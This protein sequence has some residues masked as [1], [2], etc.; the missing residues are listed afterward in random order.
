MEIEAL[1]NEMKAVKLAFPNRTIDEILKLFNIQALMNLTNQIK[2]L[3][4][5]K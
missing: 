5:N 3:R 2:L 4:I 1:I